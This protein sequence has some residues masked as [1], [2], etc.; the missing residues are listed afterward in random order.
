MDE[1]A[2][3]F[4]ICTNFGKGKYAKCMEQKMSED[5]QNKNQ[6]R[7]EAIGKEEEDKKKELGIKKNDTADSTAATGEREAKSSNSTNAGGPSRTET[8]AHAQNEKEMPEA[9]KRRLKL[10]LRQAIESW[11]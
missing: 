9:V 7:S 4:K 6:K 3:R 8:I 10:D 2:S 11:S 5:G 1:Q